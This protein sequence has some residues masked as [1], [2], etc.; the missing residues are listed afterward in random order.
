MNIKN[1]FKYPRKSFKYASND[2]S[3]LM[4]I[5]FE[6]LSSTFCCHMHLAL[7]L[8]S[9]KISRRGLTKKIFL[10]IIFQ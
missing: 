2:F 7:V 4:T 6:F 3:Y 1:D 5:L 10:N 8:P 9:R